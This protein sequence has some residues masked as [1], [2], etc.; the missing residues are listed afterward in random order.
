MEIN[1]HREQ[2]IIEALRVAK[3]LTILLVAEIDGR[4]VR[5]IAFSPVTMNGMKT[6]MNWAQFQ[7]IRTSSV[8]DEHV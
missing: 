6:G 2:F 3:A 8:K 4:V 7:D 5:H 1:E